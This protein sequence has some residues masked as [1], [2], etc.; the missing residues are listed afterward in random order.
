MRNQ[1]QSLSRV[2]HQQSMETTGDADVDIIAVVLQGG[3]ACVNLAMVRGGRHLGDRAYF[4]SQ[5]EA[6]T[7]DDDTS[8]EAHRKFYDE[9]NAVLDM[10]AAYYLETI[11]TVFQDFSLVKGTWDVK[12]PDGQV[13]R[14]RPQDITASA[15]LT[16]EGELD[17]ISGAGQ[18]RAAHDLCTGVP[19]DQHQHLE[20]E[21][22]GHY[23]IF[24]GRRWRET[25]YP[26][27]R[28]FILAHTTQ[29]PVP[30]DDGIGHDA[31]PVRSAPASQATP[32]AAAVPVEAAPALAPAATIEAPVP[33]AALE[34]AHV[35]PPETAKTTLETALELGQETVLAT[36]EGPQVR[37]PE[38]VKTKPR[39]VRGSRR[40]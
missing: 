4:P 13:E 17:D 18:T 3:R 7:V 12:S 30:V 19:A 35:T 25:V 22:A 26:K 32:V 9:Y 11:Y 1:I 15:I 8:I 2:L 20:V 6:A 24:S 5:V 21:G 28:D 39:A 38:V 16:V 10:D 31:L 34:V 40:N 33:E 29:A 27:V 37:A 23:G 14:V 36:T